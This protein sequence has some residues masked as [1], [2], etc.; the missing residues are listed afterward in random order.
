MSVF[1]TKTQIAIAL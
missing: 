1:K